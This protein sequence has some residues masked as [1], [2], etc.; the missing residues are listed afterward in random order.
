MKQISKRLFGAFL[1]T[2]MLVSMVP[3]SIFKV[4]ATVAALQSTIS[5]G[6]IITFGSYPQIKVI[7]ASLITALNAQTL[8]ADNT[9]TYGGS[10]YKRVY[11]TQYTP[12]EYNDSATADNSNQDNNGYYINTVY[13][14]KYEPI[15]WRVLSNKNGELFVMADKILDSMAY[16]QVDTKVTWETCTMRSWL[17]NDFYDTAFNL[18]EQPKIVTSTVV[19]A[20]SPLGIAG[21]NNTKDKLYLLSYADTINPAYGFSSSCDTYDAARRAQGTDYAKSSGLEVGSNSYYLKNGSWWLRT[22]GCDEDCA[23][24]IYINGLISY[25]N[26]SYVDYTNVGIRPA[27]KINLSSLILVSSISLSKNTASLQTGKTL[28]LTATVNPSN[29]NYKAVAL[30]TSSSAVAAVSSAGLITAKSIGKATITCTAKDGSGKKATCVITVIPKTPATVKATR[31]GSTSIKIS[32]TD[33]TGATGYV[34]YRYNPTTKSYVNIKATTATSY[35]NTGLKKGITYT[36][37]VKA[38]KI[39]SGVNIY[40]NYSTTASAKPY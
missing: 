10:K 20:N 28:Q 6:D 34:V 39:V 32:W 1:A 8:Q 33:V 37:K 36:Y 13:W 16:N 14:F 31:A 21:G 3:T 7:N 4:S 2:I 11:F 38:Y 30:K 19:N 17:N 27:I 26:D 24:Y 35:I 25:G 15:Q 23:C 18:I 9:V 29:A 22:P 12:Y 5:T 40:S